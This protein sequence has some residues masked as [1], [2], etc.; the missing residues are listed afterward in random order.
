MTITSRDMDRYYLNKYNIYEKDYSRAWNYAN[1]N[2]NKLIMNASTT[3]TKHIIPI[4]VQ[5]SRACHVP[6]SVGVDIA[7][8]ISI[9][10]GI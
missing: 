9:S 2:W 1:K 10:I 7:N 5:I 8:S 3:Y 4:S 6:V